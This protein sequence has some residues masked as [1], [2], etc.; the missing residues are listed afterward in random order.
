MKLIEKIDAQYRANNI[1]L[2]QAKSNDSK[3]ATN[4][5]TSY[6]KC[7]APFFKDALGCSAPFNDDYKYRKNYTEEFFP[8]D[9][10]ATNARWKTREKVALVKGVK[11]QMVSHIKSRQSRQVCEDSRR[12]RGKL[13]KLKFISSSKDLESSPMIDI[14]ESIQKNYPDF[15]VN[16]SLISFDDLQSSHSVSECMGMWYSYLRPDLNR[17]VFTNEEDLIIA[18]AMVENNSRDW[19]DLAALLDNRS[20]LQCFVHFHASFARICPSN[21]RWSEREDAIMMEATE[22]FSLNGVIN[23]TKVGNVLPSRNKTQ[24]YN[25]YMILVK[26]QGKKKGVFSRKEDRLILGYVS[27]MGEKAFNTM[28]VDFIIGRSSIQIKNHYNVAL[29]HKGNVHPWTR[30]EDK[31]LM[32]IVENEGT[33][34]W[35]KIA[36]ILGTHNRISCRTRFITISKFFAKNPSAKLEDVPCKTKTIT[37]VQKAESISDDEDSDEGN[38]ARTKTLGEKNFQTFKHQQENMYKLLRTTFNY[39][40]GSREVIADNFKLRVL[41]WLF[42]AED[43][44]R[45]L[46]KKHYMFTDLQMKKLREAFATQLDG[47]IM[48]EMRFTTIHTQFLMPPNYHTAIGL[49]A[50]TI[51]LDEEDSDE[52]ESIVENPMVKYKSALENFQKLYFSLFYW[53]AMLSKLDKDEL[54]DIHFMKFPK[55]DISAGEI[56]RQL[57]KRK[58]SAFSGFSPFE[59]NLSQPIKVYPTPKRQKVE[60]L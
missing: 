30:N 32:E 22:K 57:H 41:M 7:G 37:A 20:S 5:K 4:F 43:Y 25:R 49:R 33:N 8:F 54:S 27:K 13:Q 31:Q 2:E 40:L 21:V 45:T 50:V 53:T 17:E 14:Y 26:S 24:C 36:S 18:N 56:F 12:T 58:P 35:S 1:F 11:N 9:L 28:P 44:E 52:E 34:S 47:K 55:T 42:K 38:G 15:S 46:K 51:R 10:P 39:D 19:H 59:H 60:I 16:W 29:K 48:R 6:I 23:W 3:D